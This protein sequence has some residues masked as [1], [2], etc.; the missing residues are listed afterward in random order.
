VAVTVSAALVI[1]AWAGPVAR[2][3]GG[4][5]EPVPAARS[6]YVVR[7]G[8][9]LWSIAERLAPGED[10]RPLVD[11]IEAANHVDP[12]ALV[13]GSTLVIPS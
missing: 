13:P 6:S 8:D 1:A 5:H 2:A 7:G 12:G 4:G 9:T 3:L 11:A 10:P